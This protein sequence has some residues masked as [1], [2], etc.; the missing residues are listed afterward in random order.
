MVFGVVAEIAQMMAVDEVAMEEGEGE[1]EVEGE[2]EK[3]R[4]QGEI[5]LCSAVVGD[6][7]YSI[8]VVCMHLLLSARRS[9]WLWV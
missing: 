6:A 7:S 1:R 9:Q 8:D 4:V 2:E 3:M 5:R